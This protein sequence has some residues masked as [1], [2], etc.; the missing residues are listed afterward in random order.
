MFWV[1]FKLQHSKEPFHLLKNSAP[2]VNTPVEI[3]AYMSAVS[4]NMNEVMKT[5]SIIATITLPLGVISGIYGTNFAI[6]PGQ[7]FAYSF[8]IMVVGMF[9]LIAAMMLFFKKREWF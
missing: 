9:L 6:L 7:N 2:L 1:S 8:W 3:T 5:L 4:N